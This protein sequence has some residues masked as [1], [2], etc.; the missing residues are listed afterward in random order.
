[1]ACER[2]VSEVGSIHVYTRAG[3]REFKDAGAFRIP[4]NYAVRPTDN[5]T[6][7]VRVHARRIRVA[8]RESMVESIRSDEK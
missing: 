2:L 5:D 8:I 6:G 3:V 1:V 4:A 7:D